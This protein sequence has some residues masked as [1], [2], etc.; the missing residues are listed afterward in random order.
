M[1]KDRETQKISKEILITYIKLLCIEHLEKEVVSELTNYVYPIDECLKLCE[2]YEN[3]LGCAYL[4]ERNGL[5][6]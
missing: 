6:K 3:R 5:Y 4:Y 2:K 1:L